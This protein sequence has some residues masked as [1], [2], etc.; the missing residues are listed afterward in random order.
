M[1]ISSDIID[2]SFVRTWSFC[3]FG[4]SSCTNDRSLLCVMYN[5]A[6]LFWIYFARK[7]RNTGVPVR[8][9]LLALNQQRLLRRSI[10]L[11]S[12]SCSS[13]LTHNCE[14]STL[15]FCSWSFFSFVDIWLASKSWLISF[16]IWSTSGCCASAAF[17]HSFI[18]WPLPHDSDAVWRG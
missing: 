11:D 15:L 18:W 12:S 1:A 16:R 4:W 14:P 9:I 5:N 7:R 6:V 17:F 2:S 3:S 8:R 13:G 10:F